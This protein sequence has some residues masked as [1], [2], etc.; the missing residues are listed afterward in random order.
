MN[1]HDDIAAFFTRNGLRVDPCVKIC[2]CSL[3]PP[4]LTDN[5][6]DDKRLSDAIEETFG[7]APLVIPLP[8]K[9]TLSDQLRAFAFQVKAVVAFNGCSWELVDLFPIDD[10]RPIMGVAVDLGSSTVVFYLVDLVGQKVVDIVSLENAQASY[11]DDVL[12]RIYLAHTAKGLQTLQA[13]VLSVFA[14]AIRF[15]ETRHHIKPDNLY[16]MTIAGN[17]VMIHFLLRLSVKSLCQEPYIPVANNPGWLRS[18]DL[19]LPIHPRAVCYVFPNVGSYA[20]GDLTSGIL[21]SG[22]Y[23]HQTVSC[24]I[25]VGTNAEVVIGNQDSLIVAAGSAG[26]GLEG[27]VLEFGMKAEPGAIDKVAIHPQT[28]EIDYRTIANAKPKGLCGS[29]ALDLLAQMLQARLINQTGSLQK[30]KLPHRFKKT[31]SG[32]AFIVVYSAETAIN[33]DITFSQNDIH[34][35][36]RSKAAMYAILTVVANAYGVAF[37]EIDN[38]YVAGNFGSHIDPQNAVLIGMLPEIA[39]DRLTDLGNASGM[40]AVC[41]LLSLDAVKAVETILNKMFYLEM[42]VDPSFMNELTG[43]LFLPHTRRDLFPTTWEQIVKRLNKP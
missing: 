2:P 24:M 7:V 14:Q 20:G 6:G 13:L 5:R 23:N 36:M 43:A 8:L 15:F 28:L 38:F 35:L 12:T 4:T 41:A 32:D 17:T 30:D 19:P 22:I 27:G 10:N 34:N 39:S 1:Q 40:G 11:G 25:D 3:V 33:Q 26:P 9:Q 18:P 37:D 31:D 21:S 16:A 42:N 29:G